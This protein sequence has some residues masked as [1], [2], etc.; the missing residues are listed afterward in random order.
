MLMDI[1]LWG[2][3]YT[4]PALVVV[5]PVALLIFGMIVIPLLFRQ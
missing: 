3:V 2:V 4:V 1:A 5:L